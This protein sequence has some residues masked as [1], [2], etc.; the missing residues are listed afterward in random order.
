MVVF[1]GPI[2]GGTDWRPYSQLFAVRGGA[3][4]VVLSECLLGKRLA[5]SSD[6]P[7]ASTCSVRHI[8]PSESGVRVVFEYWLNSNTQATKTNDLP[9]L[10][11][12]KLL[13]EA[14][15]SGK[16]VNHSLG[17]YRVLPFL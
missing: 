15:R 14:D 5:I 1:V 3:T 11:I 10:E 13:D 8:E 16:T 6:A 17:D 12:K 7:T 2:P 4:P 9:W